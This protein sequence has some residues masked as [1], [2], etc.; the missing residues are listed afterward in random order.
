MCHSTEKFLQQPPH[1][2]AGK[3]ILAELLQVEIPEHSIVLIDEIERSLHP[4]LQWRLIRDLAQ[5]A[6]LL[7]LQIIVTTHSPFVLDELPGVAHA[8]IIQ[9]PTGCT[10]VYVAS[11]RVTEP[12]WNTR[13]FRTLG[14]INWIHGTD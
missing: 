9:T 3:I 14:V 8:Q 10:F 11:R 1:Q 6:R 2:G 7:E 4:T 12:N 13:S 5:L